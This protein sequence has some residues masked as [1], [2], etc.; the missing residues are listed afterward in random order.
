MGGWLAV[1]FAGPSVP[2]VG[3]VRSS[4]MISA[5]HRDRELVDSIQSYSLIAVNE[6]QALDAENSLDRKAW[7]DS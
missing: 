5:Q 4:G 7:M 2:L 6:A 1:R 3:L